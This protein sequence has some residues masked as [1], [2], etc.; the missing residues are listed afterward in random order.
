MK[1]AKRTENNKHQLL[2]VIVV[3]TIFNQKSVQSTKYTFKH[4]NFGMPLSGEALVCRG[5]TRTDMMFFWFKTG[6]SVAF[7]IKG[8][9]T[10]NQFI[11]D[12]SN[13]YQYTVLERGTDACYMP[14]PA[15]TGWLFIAVLVERHSIL[16]T[17]CTVTRV[18][19]TRHL[20]TCSGRPSTLETFI[21]LNSGTYDE[22]PENAKF[23]WDKNQIP[24]NFFKAGGISVE[25]PFT[26]ADIDDRFMDMILLRPLSE[27]NKL[28]DVSFEINELNNMRQAYKIKENKIFSPKT[29]VQR[30]S[31]DG[32]R[33]FYLIPDASQEMTYYRDALSHSTKADMRKTVVCQFYI[34]NPSVMT[35]NEVYLI[36]M[37]TEPDEEQ[38]L[39]F[40][41]IR[42]SRGIRLPR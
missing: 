1:R 13:N 15:Y 4:Y 31:W 35:D 33:G 28:Y 42:A 17:K 8:S 22:L 21:S 16:P 27:V 26:A 29:F 34:S 24:E 39:D 6:T 10:A 18:I 12:P 32:L 19:T 40:S 36:S 5:S 9:I 7:N 25:R 14:D 2:L 20:V 30:N 23:N 41:K 3:F 11:Q 38:H 37:D